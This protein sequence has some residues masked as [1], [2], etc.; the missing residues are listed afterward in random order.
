MKNNIRAL[1]L[2]TGVS[3]RSISQLH[4]AVNDMNH[5]EFSVHV[6]DNKNDFYNWTKNILRDKELANDLIECSTIEAVKFCLASKINSK[7]YN[8]AESSP[9]EHDR[10]TDKFTELPRG[11]HPKI[12]AKDISGNSSEADIGES[13]GKGALVTLI[14]LN[15]IKRNTLNNTRRI[16]TSYDSRVIAEFESKP[17]NEAINEIL[18]QLKEVFKIE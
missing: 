3:V 1:E 7:N 13:V 16:K 10:E 12:G 11:Y 18:S 4:S 6:N 9:M 5:N 15:E 17:R 2:C 8:Q 14:N